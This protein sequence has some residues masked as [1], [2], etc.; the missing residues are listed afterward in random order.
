MVRTLPDWYQGLRIALPTPSFLQIDYNAVG[1]V[2][3]PANSSVTFVFGAGF[4]EDLEWI[5]PPYRFVFTGA[6]FSADD[7]VRIMVEILEESKD[8]P[9]SY[10]L[11]FRK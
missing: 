5:P 1:Y 8:N 7:N 2:K 6:S 9:G 3:V 4:S 11:R 10:K